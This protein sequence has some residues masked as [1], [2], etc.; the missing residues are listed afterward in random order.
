MTT[1]LPARSE[2]DFGREP[3]AALRRELDRLFDDFGAGALPSW[4]GNGQF[5]PEAD[6]AETDKDI[7]VTAE[8][9]GVDEKDVEVTLN[10]DVLTI[11]GEKRSQRDEKNE[12]YQL[13]E[14]SYGSF[15]RSMS[16]PRGIDADKIKAT[17]DKGVLKVTL[18]KP[19]E[20]QAQRHQI[21]IS[22]AA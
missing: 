5:L 20:L 22:S 7:V 8:L 9:P 10:D 15:E 13:A 3:F 11:R 17:F 12:R 18:P 21:K 6:Y 2:T 14:R 16:V 1:N 4:N 19:A